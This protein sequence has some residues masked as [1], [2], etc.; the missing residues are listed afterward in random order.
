MWIFV[1]PLDTVFCRDGRPFNAGEDVVARSLFPPPPSTFYGAFRA[2]IL[3]HR[4]IPFEDFHKWTKADPSLPEVGT[5]RQIGTLCLGGPWISLL[6]RRTGT[7]SRHLFPAPCN[8]VLDKNPPKRLH[9]LVPNGSGSSRVLCDPGAACALIAAPEGTVTQSCPGYLT[10]EGAI[11]MLTPNEK[12]EP[13][14]HHR[15]EHQIHGTFRQVGIKREKGTRVVEEGM[16]YAAEHHQLKHPLDTGSKSYGFMLRVEETTHLPE[17]GWLALGGESR[18][19]AFQTV[20]VPPFQGN[21]PRMQRI[22][23]HIA[24]TRRFF[25]WLLTPAVFTNGYIPGFVDSETLQGSL[26]GL[27]LKLVACQLGRKRYL[28]G[29]RIHD[30]SSK[31]GYLSVPAGS[32]YFFEFL[33]SYE[34]EKIG[35]FFDKLSFGTLDGQVQD[36]AA[37]GFG[38]TLI[39]GY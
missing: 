29:F 31:T 7:Y 24:Q 14:K 25:L 1:E 39:G 30:R 19:A 20:S 2:A 18:A 15:E 16:L 26:D 27:E 13:E 3:A 21:E 33:Q 36:M 5:P 12:P 10:T 28:A 22:K 23:N 4:G 17:R 9:K 38:T 8:L 35:T 34:P 32:V 37:Q 11:R 6:D